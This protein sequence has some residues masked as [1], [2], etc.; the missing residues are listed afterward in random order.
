[1]MLSLKDIVWR[2]EIAK[3]VFFKNIQPWGADV[4]PYYIIN[5]EEMWKMLRNEGD[6]AVEET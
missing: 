4:R 3:L 6:N 5:N 2:L 1:M